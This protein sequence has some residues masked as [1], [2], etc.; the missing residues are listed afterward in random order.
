MAFFI[1]VAV[2]FVL[3]FLGIRWLCPLPGWT[4]VMAQCAMG[5][6]A[7]IV[8]LTVATWAVSRWDDTTHYHLSDG[9][10]G[11]RI[12]IRLKRSFLKR[13]YAKRFVILIWAWETGSYRHVLRWK[14]DVTTRAEDLLRDEPIYRLE[15]LMKFC[16]RTIVREAGYRHGYIPLTV[17][18]PELLDRK[19]KPVER[20]DRDSV[21]SWVH[22]VK[23]IKYRVV[24]EEPQNAKQGE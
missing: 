7:N 13:N 14:M 6:C 19:G 16:E 2:V 17:S 4:G 21:H 15:A 8:E 12:E 23:R 22:R 18:K 1:F 11:G 24:R 10:D 3:N 9:L 20:P 5:A